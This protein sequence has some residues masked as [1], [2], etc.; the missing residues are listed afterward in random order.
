MKVSEVSFKLNKPVYVE[1][2]SGS[3]IK[4]N[5]KFYFHFDYSGNNILRV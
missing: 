3:G 2:C 1:A 5:K 4:T